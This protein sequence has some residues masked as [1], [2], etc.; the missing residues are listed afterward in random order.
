[1]AQAREYS[2][3]KHAFIPMPAVKIT[4]PMFKKGRAFLMA[5]GLL[6]AHG[7]NQQVYLHLLGQAYENIGKAL[8]LNKD[9]QKYRPI[10]RKCIGH[11]LDLL[12]EAMCNVGETNFLSKEAFGDILKLN[13]YYKKHHLR[14]GH[15]DDFSMSYEDFFA[16]DLHKNLVDHLDVLNIIFD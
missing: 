7:G 13:K 6:L 8:I 12:T 5:S 14:Y 3:L 11:D 2:A 1:M 10:L 15:E 9:Y 4:M 16:Q